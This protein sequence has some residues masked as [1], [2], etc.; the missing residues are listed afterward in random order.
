MKANSTTQ[1]RA[2]PNSKIYNESK[3]AIITALF[4]SL[5]VAS[6]S[7]ENLLCRYTANPDLASQAC[8]ILDLNRCLS[9]TKR[10]KC[11]CQCTLLNRIL[12]MWT[13]VLSS[14]QLCTSLQTT[15]IFS[16]FFCL[17]GFFLPITRR[18]STPSTVLLIS[19]K[20]LLCVSSHSHWILDS[21][22][23]CRKEKK[24]RNCQ[25]WSRIM[26]IWWTF[27]ESFGNSQFA[28]LNKFFFLTVTCKPKHFNIN[29]LLRYYYHLW[30]F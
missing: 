14:Q 12:V 5:Q 2:V 22:S 6:H 19:S 10:Q 18:I 4:V 26:N 21:D 20:Q 7:G 1:L 16:W 24:H 28:L 13:Q 27:L 25:P 9:G 3:A 8:G 15:N 30:V 17:V 11:K 29:Y 23:K